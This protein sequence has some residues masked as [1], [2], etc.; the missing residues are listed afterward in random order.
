[1]QKLDTLWGLNLEVEMPYMG[2]IKRGKEI[3][4][5]TNEQL[6]LRFQSLEKWETR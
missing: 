5:L 2:K 3:G 4:R 1:M 6:Q